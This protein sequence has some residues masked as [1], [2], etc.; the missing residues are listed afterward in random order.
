[1]QVPHDPADELFRARFVH[2]ESNYDVAAY[3]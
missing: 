1:V 2:F 3:L